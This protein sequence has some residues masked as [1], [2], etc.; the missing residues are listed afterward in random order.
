MDA[1]AL[2]IDLAHIASIASLV[3]AQVKGV[4]NDF[5]LWYPKPPIPRKGQAS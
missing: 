1:W 2:S 5:H 4:R 3:D